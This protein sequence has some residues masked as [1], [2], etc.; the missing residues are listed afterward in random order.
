MDLTSTLPSFIS[1]SLMLGLEPTG[2]LTWFGVSDENPG[3]TSSVPRLELNTYQVSML[4]L[5][6]VP[7]RY[8]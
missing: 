7:D 6:R 5:G 1:A 8:G 3:A 2:K 4:A